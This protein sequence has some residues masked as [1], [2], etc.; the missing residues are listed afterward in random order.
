MLTTLWRNLLL[1]NSMLT[2]CPCSFL[3]IFQAEHAA[4]SS[5]RPPPSASSKESTPVTTSGDRTRVLKFANSSAFSSAWPTKRSPKVQEAERSA[6]LLSLTSGPD[7]SLW[8]TNADP[9]PGAS[10]TTL[11]ILS[12]RNWM[13][14][15]LRSAWS[16]LWGLSL[17]FCLTVT[18]HSEQTFRKSVNMLRAMVPRQDKSPHQLSHIHCRHTYSFVWAQLRPRVF[19]NELP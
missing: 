13:Q 11:S 18:F 2:S 10:E 8:E 5:W 3:G 15:L 14:A 4:R 12:A 17:L 1:S 6:A 16:S 9:A 7:M 19:W